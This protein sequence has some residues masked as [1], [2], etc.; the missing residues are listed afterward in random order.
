MKGPSAKF[1]TSAASEKA[2]SISPASVGERWISSRMK[3]RSG[4]IIAMLKLTRKK[5]VQRTDATGMRP[6]PRIAPLGIAPSPRHDKNKPGTY[7]PPDCGAG[8]PVA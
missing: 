2:A 4:V 3:G 1:V 5:A 7:G 6:P 8:R